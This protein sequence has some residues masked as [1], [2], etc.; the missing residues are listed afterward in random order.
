MA[1]FSSKNALGAGDYYAGMTPD[2]D[3][4]DYIPWISAIRRKRA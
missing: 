1:Q 3:A 4:V 2:I